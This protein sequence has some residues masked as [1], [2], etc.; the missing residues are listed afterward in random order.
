[1]AQGLGVSIV[2]ALIASLLK[3][4][5]IELRPLR[6]TMANDYGIITPVGAPPS[7]AATELMKLTQSMLTT[8]AIETETI[9]ANRDNRR[10]TTPRRGKT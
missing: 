4:M 6:P 10:R 5:A 2:P 7:R 9:R 3:D 8:T 1:M